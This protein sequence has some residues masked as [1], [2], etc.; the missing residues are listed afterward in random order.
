MTMRS[1]LERTTNEKAQN[2]LI[3]SFFFDA[4]SRHPLDHTSLGFF[5]TLLFQLIGQ[6]PPD[7]WIYQLLLSKRPSWENGEVEYNTATLR[8]LI[9][10]IIEQPKDHAVFLFVDALDECHRSK[11]GGTRNLDM[12]EVIDFID[13]I[14]LNLPRLG[15]E[16]HVCLSARDVAKFGGH[17]VPRG[18]LDI[19]DHN[20]EDIKQYIK[21]KLDDGY[22]KNELNLDDRDRLIEALLQQSSRMFLW[23]SLVFGYIKDNNLLVSLKDAQKLINEL[24]QRST[25]LKTLYKALIENIRWR[26]GSST[27]HDEAEVAETR[28]ETLRLFQLIHVSMTPLNV[29]QVQMMLNHGGSSIGKTCGGSGK[30]GSENSVEHLRRISGRLIEVSDYQPRSG[31][32]GSDPGTQTVQFIHKSVQE[33][34]DH[35]GFQFL[36]PESSL[37]MAIPRAHLCVANICISVLDAS[38]SVPTEPPEAVEV[39]EYAAQFW[40]LHVRKGDDAVDEESL[41]PSK[42]MLKCTPPTGRLVQWSKDFV[43]TGKFYEAYTDMDDVPMLTLLNHRIRA[44]EF[45]VFLAYEGCAHLAQRHGRDCAKCRNAAILEKAFFAAVFRGWTRAVQAIAAIAQSHGMPI[46]VNAFDP[47]EASL[48]PPEEREYPLRLACQLG[49]SKLVE[50]LLGMG[51]DPLGPVPLGLAVARPLHIA[52]GFDHG[53]AVAS[54]LKFGAE[55]PGNILQDMFTCKDHKGYNA[56]HEAAM[57]GNPEIVQEIL[58]CLGDHGLEHLLSERNNEGQSPREIA[59]EWKKKAEDQG[60]PRVPQYAR[61]VENI[62]LWDE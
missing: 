52:I 8:S 40:S 19:S 32:G 53:M 46:D 21:Q 51:A 16:T 33:F 28:M 58:D 50:L 4:T 13:S 20:G 30:R 41:R 25:D 44:R 43:N 3:I 26:I 36:D 10:A 7:P 56:I 29:R 18:L 62:E 61:V 57:Y 23:V 48:D 14:N 59:M 15:I 27:H 12:L 54:V 47:D 9:V 38:L 5:R 22:L 17:L 1:A 55:R 35:E 2:R 60:S 24:P 39:F 11:D 34:F 45:L 31:T 37:P 42:A 49:R 6:L